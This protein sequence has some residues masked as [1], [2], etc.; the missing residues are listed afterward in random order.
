VAEKFHYFN[1]DNKPAM[2][3]T[4][5]SCGISVGKFMQAV[6]VAAE[7][8]YYNS[9]NQPATTASDQHRQVHASGDS[10]RTFYFIIATINCWNDNRIILQYH[11]R[12]AQSGD[13]GSN[14]NNQLAAT[15][16]SFYG[17]IIAASGDSN[18]KFIIC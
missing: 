4:T 1:S 3:I 14:S 2:M 9:N 7:F 17:I 18:R 6:T 13:S 10:G 8:Y 12:R 5:S 16:A 11:H 15:T